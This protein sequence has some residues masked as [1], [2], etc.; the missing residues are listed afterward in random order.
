MAQPL[1]RLNPIPIHCPIPKEMYALIG[2]ITADKPIFGL[3][4]DGREIFIQAPA[5]DDYY[6]K[7]KIDPEDPFY[8][9]KTIQEN[10]KLFEWYLE[11]IVRSCTSASS[12]DI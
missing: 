3:F 4:K 8:D 1:V 12:I 2:G 7:E 5:A 9:F 10:R 6:K 11:K